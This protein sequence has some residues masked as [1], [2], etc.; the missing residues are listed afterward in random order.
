MVDGV[1]FFF[2]FWNLHF[3][4]IVQKNT[5]KKNNNNIHTMNLIC[6]L[7]CWWT[8]IN[9]Q[10]QAHRG[11]GVQ[12]VWCTTPDLSKGPL[13]ATKWAKNVVFAVKGWGS[14][15][16]HFWV[17]KLHFSGILHLA[18]NPGYGPDRLCLPRHVSAQ[19]LKWSW[20]VWFLAHLYIL[21]IME[22]NSI[23]LDM[24]CMHTAILNTLSA[25]CSTAGISKN[26]RLSEWCDIYTPLF[27]FLNFVIIA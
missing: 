17:Q 4:T 25:I 3:V 27:H 23:H 12:G 15:K 22:L 20:E 1:I 16:V 14:K 2:F 11:G 19:H 24:K 13:F 18:S 6:K 26:E 10:L 9:I 7:C 21:I 8:L 5:K